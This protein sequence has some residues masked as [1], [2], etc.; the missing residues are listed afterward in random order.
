MKDTITLLKKASKAVKCGL[1]AKLRQSG[2]TRAQW[3]VIRQISLGAEKAK[4]ISSALNSDKPTI[5]GIIKRLKSGGWITFEES[6]KDRRIKRLSLSPKARLI[7]KAGTKCGN[8]V[9]T[10]ALKGI[11]RREQNLLNKYLELMIKNLK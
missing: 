3:D 2:L 5:S 1:D 11:G 6:P 7:I 10:R 4:D 9:K 8:T